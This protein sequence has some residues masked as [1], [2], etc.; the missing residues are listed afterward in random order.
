MKFKLAAALALTLALPILAHTAALAETKAT[1]SSASPADACATAP[2]AADGTP[3]DCPAAKPG[4]LGTNIV[5]L[6]GSDHDSEG[7][8]EGADGDSD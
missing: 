2:K 5:P 7:E 6:A 1:I 8:S 4:K 3:T